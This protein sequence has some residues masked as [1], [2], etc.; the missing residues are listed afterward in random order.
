MCIDIRSSETC[1][2]W[3]KICDENHILLSFKGEFNHNLV[4]SILLHVDNRTHIDIDS[5]VVKN[6]IFA[7]MVEA[8]QNICKHGTSTFENNEIKPG[9]VI[10]ARKSKSYVVA[11]GNLI[12]SKEAQKIDERI[13]KLQLASKQELLKLEKHILKT[14][15]LSNKSGAGLGLISITRKAD[16]VNYCIRKI[17]DDYSFFEL[18][19]IINDD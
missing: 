3:F 5:K 8:L 18:E 1:Y 10:L 11:T 15:Q 16:K 17:D 9:I 4:N 6:R 12:L 7:I 13:N 2:K 14:G 19:I